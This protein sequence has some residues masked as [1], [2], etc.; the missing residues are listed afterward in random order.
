M[1][2][3]FGAYRLKA[4]ERE[5]VGPNGPVAL[6]ARSFDILSAFLERP[7]ELVGKSDLLDAVWPGVA[8]E[9]NTLH[10]HMSALRKALGPGFIT[11]V[12]GR[13]YR[14]V[15]PVPRRDEPELV[16]LPAGRAGNL[17]RYRVECVARE[18]ETAAV[19]DLLGKHRL[20]SILGAGGVGKTTLALAVAT[21]LAPS[22]A[23]GVWVIDLAPVADGAL[24]ESAII[25]AMGIPFRANSTPLSVIGETLRA[26]DVLLVVDNC[27]HVVADVARV[28]R[29]LVDEA[30]GLRI[31]AT[32]QVPLG[33]AGEHLFRLA[34]FGL[35]AADRDASV[36]QSAQ[37]LAYCY[38]A[39][40][41]SFAPHELPIVA[42]LCRRL[43]GVAL[44]LKMA[45]AQAAT[46][47]IETVDRQ[48]AERLASL[49]AGW[50]PSLERHRSLAASLSWSYELLSEENRRTLRSLGVFQG[51]FT[52]AGA[53]AVAA[54][55]TDDS[56]SELVRRS[57]VV[58]EGAGRS[59][60][61]LL[62]TTRHFALERLVEAG[63]EAAARDRHAVFIL[64]T[65]MAGLDD[66]ETAPDGDWLAALQPDGDNLRSALDWSRTQA[67]WPV[68]T[69]LA[70]SSY[71]FWIQTQLPAEGLRAAQAAVD[72]IDDVPLPVAALLNLA[73]AELYRFYRL[74]LRVLDHLGPASAYY[75]T[76]D[77][78]TRSVQ[79]QILEGWS[80]MVLLRYEEARVVFRRIDPAVAAMPPGKLKA[81]ALVLVGMSLWGEG[82]KVVGRAKLEAGLAMHLATGNQRGYLKSAML[83][84]EIM[85]W[86]GDTVD[87]IELATRVMPQVRTLGNAEEHA[88]QIT[89]LCSYLMASGDYEGAR[90]LHI[91]GTPRMPRDDKNGMWCVIQ[92]A[93]E[94]AA[95]D[96]R[97]E[98]AA[99]LLGFA[100]AGFDSWED[101][102]QWTEVMQRKRIVAL[103][104][105][106]RMTE[107]D[108]AQLIV[109]GGALS[110]FEAEMLAKSAR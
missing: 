9:E 16:T 109:Q 50:Q 84:A 66:W 86:S 62:E 107:A 96:G 105:A 95:Y 22:F 21:E 70:A 94:L 74:D 44:A 67:N 4:N 29:A 27:E 64:Q 89:N 37:F 19:R 101:G 55:D 92:N 23:G 87:A 60:Y 72:H 106:A 28:A 30:P 5:L 63:E 6:S 85:H 69:G 58:R 13:G 26:T 46:L 104:E 82:D 48:I 12:H 11:T 39:L 100:D 68:H 93:A 57:I 56:L 88:G 97:A 99:L 102:R 52:L 43:D 14:Y 103:L 38:E 20:V 42:Q 32:T 36:A 65:F 110:L 79:T 34:P 3:T 77:D 15:G 40:G 17:P 47:G 51:S 24:V 25:Q 81:R 61:R 108:R 10:V 35:D 7:N 31:L 59:H 73:L 80:L 18:T 98:T 1:G 75:A 33:I 41:E 49:S 78:L 54:T 53:R 91:E 76:S 83:S 71:R 8:V 90:T 45:A 2:L